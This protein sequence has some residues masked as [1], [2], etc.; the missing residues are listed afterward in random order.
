MVMI[1]VL[2]FRQEFNGIDQ[3]ARTPQTNNESDRNVQISPLNLYVHEINV[4]IEMSSNVE[5]RLFYKNL[6]LLTDEIQNKI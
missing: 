6:W 5:L 3:D 1:H 2:V 4:F